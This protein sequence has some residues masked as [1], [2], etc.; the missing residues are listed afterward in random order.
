MR[1]LAI[2]LSVAA[3]AAT[4]ADAGTRQRGTL[5]GDVTRGPIAPMCAAE[6]PC[7]APA[8][9]LTLVFSRNSRP[10]GRVTTD[11]V[12]HYRLRLP[13]GF[14]DVRRA[15]VTGFDRRLEPNTVRVRSGR[16]VR[17]D[18]SIETGIR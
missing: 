2:G 7:D 18:F 5:Y 11:A 15:A 8:K 9:N 1:V 14:Y 6:Q 12:G 4:A 13:S 10:A 17:V 3:I 16:T